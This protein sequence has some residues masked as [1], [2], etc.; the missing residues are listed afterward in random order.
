MLEA[1]GKGKELTTKEYKKTFYGD[2]NILYLDF[3]C[4]TAIFFQKSEPYTLKG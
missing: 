1:E 4:Y 3:T 2:R